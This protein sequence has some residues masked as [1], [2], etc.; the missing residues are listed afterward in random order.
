M[1]S[2]FEDSLEIE[3]SFLILSIFSYILK[4]NTQTIQELRIILCDERLK[5]I[6][7]I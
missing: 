2:D 3:A 1:I 4:E 5:N 7:P 6:N